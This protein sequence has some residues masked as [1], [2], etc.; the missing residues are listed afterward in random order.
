[1]VA[2]LPNK[3]LAGGAYILYTKE[4][5]FPS[6]KST[7]MLYVAKWEGETT[8]K[9][10]KQSPILIPIPWVLSLLTHC[11]AQTK[12]M[13]ISKSKKHQYKKPSPVVTIP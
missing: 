7:E 1:M 5:V 13:Q 2:F 6:H 4:G 12:Q 11:F 3:S 9:H 10:F 8:N